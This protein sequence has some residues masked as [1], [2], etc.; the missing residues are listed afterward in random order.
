LRLV[1]DPALAQRL[2]AQGK[3]TVRHYDWDAV[4]DR[5]EGALLA[6]LEQR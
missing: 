2:V 6:L 3:E 5:V 1:H 4:I